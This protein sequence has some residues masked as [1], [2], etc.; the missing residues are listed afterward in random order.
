MEARGIHCIAELYDCPAD[1]LNDEA[2][3]KQALRGAVDQGMATLLGEVSHRF[4]PQGVTVLGLIAESHLA[5]HTWP[6]FA[7]AAADV[8]TCGDRAS[9][10]KAC[11]HLV[12]ALKAGRHSIKKLRRGLDVEGSDAAV[13]PQAVAV[14]AE[15]PNESARSS[16]SSHLA[17]LAAL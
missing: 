1:L 13:A 17:P 15:A 10:E 3:I 7:Y 11:E 8:F 6:E 9:A 12:V 4:H 14:S 5:I 16:S 2:Y